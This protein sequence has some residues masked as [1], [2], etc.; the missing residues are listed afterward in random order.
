MA[1][2]R[3]PGRPPTRLTRPGQ[4]N[5]GQINQGQISQNQTSQGQTKQ[6]QTSQNQTKQD[7]TNPGPTNQN[8]TNPAFLASPTSQPGKASS[9]PGFQNKNVKRVTYYVKLKTHRF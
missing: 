5:Q 6:D 4:I 7:Q 8:Q 2:P 9:R 1:F 3:Q